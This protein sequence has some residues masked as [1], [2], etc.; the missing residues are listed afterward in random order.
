MAP[1]LV[2]ED[3]PA[4]SSSE[5]EASSDEETESS[6]AE[7]QPLQSKKPALQK[8]EES[9]SALRTESEEEESESESESDTDSDSKR[10]VIA[11]NSLAKKSSNPKAKAASPATPVS[12]LTAGKR[13][14]GGEIEESSKDVK[15]RKEE[16]TEDTTKKRL[17]SDDDEVALL[18][19]MTEFSEKR[20]VDPTR[21]L[22]AF[23]S[24]IKRYL[25]VEV[26]QSQL[27]EKIG[28]LRRKFAKAKEEED[29]S[30]LKVHDREVF[31]LSKKIW[32][33]SKKQAEPSNGKAKVFNN[34]DS[35]KLAA[36][37]VEF[38]EGNGK[39][40]EMEIEKPEPKGAFNL[41]WTTSMEDIGKFV[42]TKGLD[43]V[44]G[45]KRGELEKR[46]K[47]VR[48]ASFELLAKRSQLMH[49]Q[50]KLMLD[51]LED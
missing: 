23:H 18:E 2:K 25:S 34:G 48:I 24:F 20:R 31:S 16:N 36:I 47:E 40:D 38:G 43:Y 49:D 1:K 45:S 17:W 13:A 33:T 41:D 27:K 10:A 28:R 21:D 42:A 26:S 51:A 5:E 22:A 37:K 7:P 12:K 32:G 11:Q 8:P 4:A 14:A 39:E 46:W 44:D 15:R 35:S 6:D 30:F 3:P 19:G 50:A 29:K 9:F